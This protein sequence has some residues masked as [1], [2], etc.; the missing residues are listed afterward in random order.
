MSFRIAV[1]TGGTFSDVVLADD[2]GHFSL[3]KAPTTPGKI[4]DGISQALEFAAAE[5]ALGLHELLA[6]TDV[7]IYAT[8]R[9]TNAIITG[10]TARTALITTEGFP[11]TLVFREGG[12]LRPFDFRQPYPEPYIPKRLTFEMPERISSEG[13]VVRELSEADAVAVLRE[14]AAA[15]VEAIAV[16]LLWSIAN[17]AHEELIGSLIERE[18]PG[19]PYTLSARLNPIIREYRRTSSAAIDASLKPLMQAHLSDMDRDL[20]AAGFAG[21]LLVVTSFGGVLR[22]EDTTQRPLYTVNSGPAMAP[23][24]GKEVAAP[25]DNIVVCDTGG[26]SFDVSVVRGGEVQFTR[27]TWLDGLFTGHITGLSSV[28]VKNVGAGGGSIAWIDSGGLLRVGPQSAGAEPGPACYGHG[29][30]DA[31]VTDAAVVLGYIDPAY[32]LG[33][34]LE[35]DAAAAHSA[36]ERAV[37]GP[38]G[39]SVQRAAW[40]ILAVANEH[41]VGAVREITIN[42]GIDPRESIVI[43]GGGAGGLTMSKIAEELGCDKVLVP[44]T[45]AALSATGG[46]LGDVVA[47]FT[48]S[49]R[50]DTNAFD[51]DLVNEGLAD[52]D[53]QIEAFFAQMDVPADARM[54]D[55]VVEA[56]YPY[57]VWELD[58]AL[59]SRRFESQADVDALVAAFHETHER[60]FAVKELGQSV[61][62]LYWKGRARV[63]LPKPTLAAATGEAQGAPSAEPRPMWWG[64]DDPQQTPV[65]LGA[66]LSAGERIAG[67]AVVELPTTTVVV[68]PGWTATVTERGDYLLERERVSA[69]GANR[70]EAA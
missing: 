10:T 49:R 48:V 58:V 11:D 9:S 41:M 61:E 53:R 17:P 33:G 31:T 15:G 4:F 67:P 20:R 63:H 22:L 7:L 27:E 39:F 1:D 37:A 38:L 55:Y 8:T 16:S 29:G 18:L 24:A 19:V 34:K 43:A 54:Q 13:D 36:V 68:Y 26:T 64:G 12:K 6:Q 70:E 59:P 69:A 62:C 42:Q 14:V 5:R 50:A 35:L 32:F 56:R 40:A 57:Q 65:F 2:A 60:V 25:I 23:V 51:R 3:S 30:T 28:D 44:Q 45:A 46:L 47:E 66:A 21:E 52:L